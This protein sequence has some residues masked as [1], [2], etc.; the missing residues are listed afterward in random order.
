MPVLKKTRSF[1]I[2]TLLTAAMGLLLFSG[3]TVLNVTGEAISAADDV[4]AP[5]LYD[6]DNADGDGNYMVEWSAVLDADDYRLHEIIDGS[7]SWELVFTGTDT[8]F[9]RSNM[10]EGQH[11]YHV[12]ALQGE[13]LS[14]WS[15]D[16]CTI[17]SDAP[18]EATSTSTLTPTATEQTPLPTSSSTSTPTS[19]ATATSTATATNTPTATP[20]PIVNLP[21]IVYQLPPTATPTATNTP[22]PTNTPTP[23]PTSKPTSTPTPR[24]M[25][26][27]GDFEKGSNGDWL[28]FSQNARPIIVDSFPS[29]VRAHS[30][31]WLA[32]LGGENNELA[33]FFQT[34]SI[35]KGRSNFTYW[36]WISSQDI[37]WDDI[38]G[39]GVDDGNEVEVFDA[40]Y[41]CVSSNTNGWVRRTFNLEK[42][43]GKTVD[44]F[45]VAET[46]STLVSS[47]YVDD[48][49]LGESTNANE[50]PSP[51]SL[52]TGQPKGLVKELLLKLQSQ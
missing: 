47:L 30:G 9:S 5:I 18:P 21:I 26:A 16:K 1:W 31:R 11:C 25:I 8:S 43:A 50:N 12:R 32:W 51:N 24:G 48:V 41:L 2:L 45:I 52:A 28:A 34:V 22:A 46:D 15:E 44:L 33:G 20:R 49:S 17:V 27:N 36:I 40:Y 4:P 23:T 3:A 19:S 10:P 14:P 38:G 13:T 7:A 35:L 37:C 6:I 29:G 42:Y 39:M